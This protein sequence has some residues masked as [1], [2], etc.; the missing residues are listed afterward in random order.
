MSKEIE[1]KYDEIKCLK[2]GICFLKPHNRIIYSTCGECL[3]KSHNESKAE[4]TLSQ[5]W[6]AIDEIKSRKV[7][8]INIEKRLNNIEGNFIPLSKLCFL[9]SSEVESLKEKTKDLEESYTGLSHEL[10]YLME[11]KASGKVPMSKWISVK[12]RLPDNGTIV[13][14]TD[15]K[16]IQKC[17][18]SDWPLVGT[19]FEIVHKCYNDYTVNYM[20]ATYW[21]PLPEVPNE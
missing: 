1:N 21:M 15:G 12:D 17:I 9:I 20:D 8:N 14:A 2:C 18:R 4:K 16:E 13:F 7:E 19:R 3:K 11:N 5:A 6:E 10:K